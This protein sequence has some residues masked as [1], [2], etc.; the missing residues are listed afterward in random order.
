[1]NAALRLRRAVR[2][3]LTFLRDAQGV[4]AIEFAFI[5]PVLLLFLVAAFDCGRLIYASERVE[6]VANEIAEML[7]ETPRSNSATVNGDGLV[8]SSDILGF[9]NSGA[10]IF[11]DVLSQAQQQNVNWDQLLQLDMASVGFT[12]TPT[13]CTTTC[14]YK[15]RVIW[16]YGANAY[17][18]TCSVLLAA[19]P[20]TAVS[21]PGAIPTDSFGP[22]SLLVVD[23]HYTWQPTF[24]AAYFTPITFARSVYL[25]PRYVTNVEATSGNGVN[26][27]P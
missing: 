4:S 16:N 25:N 6:E 23:V 18:R 13:G 27:C 15:P 24:G 19:A 3:G 7:A 5:V 1:M 12:A 2:A 11:P 17:L 22:N 26:I 9:Y 10:F 21:S 14:T 20:D 8:A